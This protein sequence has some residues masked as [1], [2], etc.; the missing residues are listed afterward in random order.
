MRPNVYYDAATTLHNAAASLFSEVDGRWNALS[1]S[2]MAGTYDEAKAWAASY[3]D[4][5]LEVSN[6]VVTTAMT[7]DSYA[8]VLRTLGHNHAIA[9]HN[10]TMG[11]NGPPPDAPPAPPPAVYTCRIPIPS[12]G[13]PSNGLDDAVNLAAKIGIIVPNGDTGKLSSVG[14]VWDQLAKVAAVTALPG[15]IERVVNEFAAVIDS[16]ETEYIAADLAQL[17]GAAEDIG[18]VFGALAAACHDHA[19]GLHELREQ[20]K[21][22][23]EELGKELLKE[24]AI[25]AVIGVATSVI[26]FGIGAAV[27]SAR[28]ATIVARYAR[29]IRD[30]IDAWKTRKNIRAGVKI[31]RDIAK[32]EKELQDLAKRSDNTAK[33]DSWGNEY[34]LTDDER[35][36]LNRGPTDRN[37]KDLV[38]AIRE[39]RLTP[40]QKEDLDLWRR[41]MDKL[42]AHEGN[43]V[44]HT[45]LTPEQLA[46]Y[47]PNKPY[48]EDAP[49]FTSKNPAGSHDGLNV[50]TSDVEYQIVSKTGRETENYGGMKEEVT[51]KDHTPFF[52]HEKYWDPVKKRT[53]IVMD[54]M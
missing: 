8:A 38:S 30:I 35:W 51:F 13:G 46:R 52:V 1:E 33:R 24:I 48:V 53:I 41:S 36:I 20:L 21:Q 49:L 16:P 4:K 31:E 25:T 11:N 54:E 39:N 28:V 47:E 15:D 40:Q 12:A 18:A 34:G 26:T 14:D 27:A 9:E 42:P 17:K 43:V 19:A 44:R 37:G 5:V 6:L 45:T 2:H 10:A 23:L 3:D 29:P 7:L 22:Q 32:R 50:G